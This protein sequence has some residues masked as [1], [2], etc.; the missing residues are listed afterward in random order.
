MVDDE[1]KLPVGGGGSAT[2]A[3]I[4]FEQQLGALIGTWMLAGS[5]VDQR[6]DLGASKPVWI[7]FETEA[8]VDD[9]LVATSANGFIA[10]QA[11]TTASLSRDLKSPFGK[12]ILQ[13]VRHWLACRDGDG[14][15]HWN[16]PLDPSKDRLVLAVGQQASASIRLELPAALR[17]RSQPG[18]A[19][20]TEGQSRAFENYASCVEQAW[21]ASTTEEFTPD[22]PDI[23]APLIESR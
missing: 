14:K 3:G 13:F 1:K 22:F 17:Y 18:G 19:M 16:R 9:I 2:S 11:K 4:L 20:L 21:I 6:L 15:R 23:L 7:R 10:I 12:T 8:P 5:S